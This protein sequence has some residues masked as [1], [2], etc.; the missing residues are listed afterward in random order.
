MKF[1][2]GDT[3]HAVVWSG[4]EHSGYLACGP[5]E[6]W[7]VRVRPDSSSYWVGNA[8]RAGRWL[9][10]ED[11]CATAREAEVKADPSRSTIS[12]CGPPS[13]EEDLMNF[14]IM[15]CPECGETPK[16]T[17]TSACEVGEQN[18]HRLARMCC[19]CGFEGY[20]GS[21]DSVEAC[22]TLW[23]ETV[24]CRNRVHLERREAAKCG[25]PKCGHCNV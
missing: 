1:K 17:Q 23:N 21:I 14:V 16:F 7:E 4:T 25:D 18:A 6:V 24:A 19:D 10:E 22:I 2:P 20:L 11:C 3:I 13:S 15:P 9:N 12:P 8:H 5:F